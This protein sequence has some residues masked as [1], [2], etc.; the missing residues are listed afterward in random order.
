MI[1]NDF[2]WMII[3]IMVTFFNIFN[4]DAQE[5]TGPEGGLWLDNNGVYI[6]AHGGGILFQNDTYYW[7]GEHKT[8][9]KAGNKANIGVHCYSSKNLIDWEDKG[10]ALRMSDDT[11]SLLVKGCILERP[12]VIYNESTKKYVMWFHHELKDQGYDAALT[13]LAVSDQVSG[14]Y[15]YIHS[16]RPNAGIWPDNFSDELKNLDIKED[17][18][19]RG[20]PEWKEWVKMEGFSEEILKEVKCLGIWRCL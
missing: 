10:I 20:S 9:G 12:K 15:E 7:F 13:G 19:E 11:T 17:T 16:I 18:L 2:H 8:E 3:W 5:L 4:S 1:R 14:P 6:N